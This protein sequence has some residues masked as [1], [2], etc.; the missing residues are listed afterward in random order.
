MST[1]AGAQVGNSARNGF[2]YASFAR[3]LSQWFALAQRDLPWRDEA[4]ARDPYRVLVSEMMLQQTTVAAVVPFYHRFLARFPTVQTLAAVSVEDV[5]PLW[6]GLGY[7]QR[8]R[9]LHAA[10]RAVM[11]K[12]G[13]EFPRELDDVLALPGVG[14]YTAGAVTSIAYDAPSPIVD[15]NVAR[16]FSRIFLIEGD[17]KNAANQ[18][19]LWHHAQNVVASCDTSD[20]ACRPSV[21]N[22]ALMELGALVCVPRSPRCEVCPVADWCAARKQNRQNELPHVA[23]KR[24][25]IQLRDFCAFIHRRVQTTVSRKGAQSL[26]MSTHVGAQDLILLRR[27]PDEKRVW[28]R[29]MWELPRATALAN[30]SGEDA[31]RRLLR[32][33]LNCD[34]D[35]QIG[36]RLK[37]VRH[38]VTHHQITLECYAV[39]FDES[40]DKKLNQ[41]AR[42]ANGSEEKASVWQWFS[43]DEARELAMPSSM[44]RLLLWLEAHPA[45]E[46]ASLF[47]EQP[48]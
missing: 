10:A 42:D 27:R 22:P 5:L 1:H 19:R 29:G 17:L 47:E 25:S 14:R 32:E 18:A 30:E 13:G 3:T 28:W 48:A 4:N 45:S 16:V 31:L 33:E 36:S 9:L 46:Q 44:R 35:F 15:A 7:Y 23:T 38:G 2:D 20:A 6:A 21:V 26:R 24:A 34:V 12:H 39:T 43:W 8:A 37:T 11:E 41:S 40:L